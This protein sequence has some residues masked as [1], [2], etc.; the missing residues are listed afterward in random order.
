MP[1][2]SKAP[3]SKPASKRGRP[4]VISDDRLLEAAR[5]VFLAR[6]IRATTAEVAERAHVSEGTIF[7]RYKTKDAL[8]R[9][10]MRFDPE[11]M[12]S[13]LEFL[14]PRADEVDLRSKLVGLALRTLSFGR[15]AVPMLMMS[16]SNPGGEYSLE[17]LLVDDAHIETSKVTK[18]RWFRGVKALFDSE[19][20]S[21][22][23]APVNSEILARM[24]LGTLR[25]Y[26]F[27]ELLLDVTP[28]MSPEAFSE[29]VVDMVL[30]AARPD[31]ASAPPASNRRLAP[32]ARLR[33][34]AAR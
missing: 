34:R 19:I 3:L 13:L 16:W 18:D 2:R 8:F 1:E 23:L 20:E 9:A 29:S 28:R 5:E 11:K 26:C 24:F 10:A 12:P 6:G 30:R 4:P 22:G 27:R 15:V 32:R 14:A 31:A 7:H 25:D 21:G 17:K 33:A